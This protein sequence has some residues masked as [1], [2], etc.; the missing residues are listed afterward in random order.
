MTGD[1]DSN[2]MAPARR[3]LRWRGAISVFVLSLSLGSV[4]C[5]R[6]QEAIV[7]VYEEPMHRLLM[8]RPPVRVLDV[9]VPVGGTSLYHLH[10]DPIFYVAIDISEIDA[11]VLGEEW[12]RTKVSAWS[13]GGV[14]HDLGHAEKPLTHRIRNSGSEPF[15]LIAVTNSGP[16]TPLAGSGIDVVLPGTMETEIEW[17]RQS[18]VVLAPG[19]ASGRTQ[20]PFPVV[21]VQVSPGQAQ[22]NGGGTEESLNGPGSFAA[23]EPRQD[24]ELR[25]SGSQPVTLV[26]IEAR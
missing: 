16:P 10:T 1:T 8:E 6:A 14:A 17:F 9:Q 5:F 24:F 4:A 2:R 11:Q 3:I 25:N 21:A 7:P 22:L 18:R 15:R 23:A 19:A 20:S 26:V 12:K 13:P